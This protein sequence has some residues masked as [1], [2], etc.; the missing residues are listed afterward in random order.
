MSE[1]NSWKS[2]L[3]MISKNAA[4]TVKLLPKYGCKKTTIYLTF[5]VRKLQLEL[6]NGKKNFEFNTWW[7]SNYC[8]PFF[9]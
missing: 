7:N 3:E 8:E 4:K 1:K 5:S 6:K 9:P 2:I